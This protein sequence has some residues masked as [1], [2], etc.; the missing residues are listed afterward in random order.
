MVMAKDLPSPWLCLISAFK[1][2]ILYSY[3]ASQ[4][5]TQSLCLGCLSFACLQL[6]YSFVGSVGVYIYILY[7]YFEAFGWRVLQHLDDEC[8]KI[9][10]S[11]GS[12]VVWK[13]QEQWVVMIVVSLMVGLW[14]STGWGTPSQ[15]MILS[16]FLEVTQPLPSYG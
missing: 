14:H 3:P 1:K 16:M 12:Q 11:T 15:L 2:T 5:S 13:Y 8:W 6:C 9:L 4:L 7:I 10:F